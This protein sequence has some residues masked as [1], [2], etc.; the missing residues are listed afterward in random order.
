[1]LVCKLPSAGQQSTYTRVSEVDRTGAQL[2]TWRAAVKESTYTWVSEV[3]RTGAQLNTWRAA[4][5]EST[6]TWVSRIHLR[7]WL[8][9]HSHKKADRS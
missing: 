7:R 9:M 1:M 6:Y 4:V 2:N 3:D 8:K 5:K